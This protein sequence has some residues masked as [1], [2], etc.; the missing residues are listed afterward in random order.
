MLD[1]LMTRQKLN[2]DHSYLIDALYWSKRSHDI[3]TQCGCV[4]VAPDHT[5]LSF[6]YNGHIRNITEGLLPLNRPNDV[7]ELDKYPFM[8]HAEINAILNCARQGKSTLNATAYITGRPCVSCLQYLWQAGICRIVYSDFNSPK[9]FN[10]DPTFEI[11][12][13]KLLGAMGLRMIVDFIPATELDLTH[14]KEAMN[15]LEP[16]S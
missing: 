8:I 13:K 12:I 4:L 9:M 15:E 2:W 5:P 3:H 11:K 16:N 7:D 14:I 1:L 6:G 10:D